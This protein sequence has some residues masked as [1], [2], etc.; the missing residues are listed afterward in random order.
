MAV[1][2]QRAELLSR[3]ERKN[4]WTIAEFAGDA[5]PDGMQR[6]LNLYSWTAVL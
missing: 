2:R 4:G 5:T 1:S 3:S 6:L